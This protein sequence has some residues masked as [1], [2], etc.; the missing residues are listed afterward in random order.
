MPAPQYHWSILDSR[1]EVLVDLFEKLGGVRL[2]IGVHHRID[3]AHR[4]VSE[5]LSTEDPHPTRCAPW[6]ALKRALFP[7]RLRSKARPAGNLT[8]GP[9][10][11][12]VSRDSRPV[13]SRLACAPLVRPPRNRTNQQQSFQEARAIGLEDSELAVEPVRIVALRIGT[14]P[15]CMSN[16]SSL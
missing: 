8:I 3:V 9:C 14:L 6:Q 16:A 13:L 1:L 4:C 2:C 7:R 11:R 10:R 5:T 12:L 15:P